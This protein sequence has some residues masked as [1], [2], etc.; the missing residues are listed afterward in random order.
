MKIYLDSDKEGPE[1]WVL[2]NTAKDAIKYLTESYNNITDIS[3]NSDLGICEEC[4]NSWQEYQYLSCEHHGTGY[5]ILKWL[6][7]HVTLYKHKPP[8]I[9]LH[10]KNPIAKIKMIFMLNDIQHKYKHSISTV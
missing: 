1:G 8:R 9:T 4:L 3:I 2:L 10:T 6:D 7:Q 5:D